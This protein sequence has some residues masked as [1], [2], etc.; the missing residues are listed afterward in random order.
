M[1]EEVYANIRMKNTK[2]PKVK[3]VWSKLQDQDMT[4]TKKYLKSNNTRM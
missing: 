2:T 1:N 3:K 4:L